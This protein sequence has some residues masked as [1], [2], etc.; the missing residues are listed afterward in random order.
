MAGEASC[1][2]SSANEER[3]RQDDRQILNPIAGRIDEARHAARRGRRRGLGRGGRPLFRSACGRADGAR[4]WRD[5]RPTEGLVGDDQVD[6]RQHGIHRH[7]QLG[8]RL[9][10]RCR[11]L[12]AGRQGRHLHF[13]IRHRGHSGAAG[14]L[15]ADRREAAGAHAVGPDL[16]RLEALR[17][18]AGSRRQSIWRAGHRQCRQL[19]L[20]PRQARPVARQRRGD[21]VVGGLRRRPH[22]R[23]CRL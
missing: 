14:R 10:A 6:R 7:Q 22:P 3:K 5:H 21:L 19:R 16:R 18:R 9:P 12:A 4:L 1:H 13:R 2:L 11:G 8:R 20:L 23:P 15:S 17:R